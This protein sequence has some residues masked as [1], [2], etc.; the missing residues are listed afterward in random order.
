MARLEQYIQVGQGQLRCG[1]TTGTCA[2]AAALVATQALVQGTMAQ[3]VTIDTPAGIAVEVEVLALRVEE[4][5]ACCTVCKDGGDDPDVTHGAHIVATVRGSQTPGITIEGGQG[6]GRVTKP[7]LDQAVGQAAI[8]SVPRQM[9]QQALESYA[10]TQGLRVEISVPNGQALA[11]KTFNPRMGIEGGIS[12]LGTSGIVRPMS[13]E[14]LKESVKLEIAMRRASGLAH[15]VITP[16]NYGEAFSRDVLA[17]DMTHSAICSNYIGFAIDCAVREGFSSVLVVGH[18]GKLSKVAAGAMNT[19]SKICDPR[20]EVFCTHA[21][22]CG[23]DGAL[24]QGLYHCVTA[25]GA[26]ELLEQAGCFTQTM[27]SM[28][29]AIDHHLCHRAGAVPIGALCFSNQYGIVATT[30]QAQALLAHHIIH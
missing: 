30:P 18:I 22:L 24:V 9:I 4:G 17:I 13:E 27:A 23:G 3:S 11:Q 28:A 16:G 1:Y 10:A 15:L 7:G 6:V 19:H 26:I 20:R 29:T 14:A 12:I 2:T 25:D 8:N 5:V 21:A